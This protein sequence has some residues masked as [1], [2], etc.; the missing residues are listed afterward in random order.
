MTTI[1]E[2]TCLKYSLLLAASVIVCHHASSQLVSDSILIEGHYRSFHYNQPPTGAKGSSL[3]FVMHGSGGNGR[4]LVR[5]MG[6]LDSAS[7]AE[8]L[9]MVYPD[10]YH[11]YWNECRKFASSEANKLNINEEAFFAA[12]IDYFEGKYG[13]NKKQVF[14]MGFSGGGHMSYKLGLT[15]PQAFRAIAPIVANM[16]DI[17]NLDCGE[18]RLPLA[19]MITNCTADG[20]N[21]YNGG[22]MSS[23]NFYMGKVRPTDS[24]FHY[25]AALAGYKGQPKKAAVPDNDPTDAITIER[26]TYQQKGKPEVVLMKVIGG[27]HDFPADRGYYFLI[28]EFFKRQMGR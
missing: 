21:P 8:K 19:V 27:G 3:L 16:P 26:Y 18:A 4:D 14:A 7:A 24:S 28:W 17:S 1:K 9:V 25:W 6:R 22:E 13:I 10:G 11:R 15:M 2:K 5:R 20:T 23:P 12:M